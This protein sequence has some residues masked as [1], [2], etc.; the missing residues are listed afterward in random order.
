MTVSK[1]DMMQHRFVLSNYGLFCGLEK[2][3]P[4][5]E[6]QIL[7][8]NALIGLFYEGDFLSFSFD[9]LW[10]KVSAYI[11]KSWVH[12]YLPSLTLHNYDPKPY[13]ICA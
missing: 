3:D 9:G 8:A 12:Q 5:L 2:L 4:Y 7:F 6:Q 11:D 13:P 10:H 1:M